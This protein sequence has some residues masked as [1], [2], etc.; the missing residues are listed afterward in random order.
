MRYEHPPETLAR[1]PEA[2]RSLASEVAPRRLERAMTLLTHR[3]PNVVAAAEAVHRRH[4]TSAIL[5]SAEAFGVHEARL[6]AHTFK[7]ARG[8]SKGADRW[9]ELTRHDDV[10]SMMAT[11]RPRGFRLYVADID[12]AAVAPEEVPVDTPIV[13]LFGSELTGVSDEA[14]A[15]ADGV[16]FIPTMGVTQSLNVSAA[17]AI[18]L[19]AVCMNARATG[20]VGITGEARD[21]FLERFVREEAARKK[22]SDH[23]FK[24]T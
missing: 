16:V 24:G 23:L 21:R 7:P 5:R 10:A 15:A 20:T 2:V 18:V 17:A 6:V 8:A 22:S 11:L 3:L 9:L 4:N 14:K 19:R 1:L 12:P 13:L